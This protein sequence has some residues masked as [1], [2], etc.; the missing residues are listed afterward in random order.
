M[1]AY[2]WERA[3]CRRDGLSHQPNPARSR[4]GQALGSGSD[5][6]MAVCVVVTS[7]TTGMLISN[8]QLASESRRDGLHSIKAHGVAAIGPKFTTHY[9][10]LTAHYSLPTTC[11]WPNMRRGLGLWRQRQGLLVRLAVIDD[12]STCQQCIEPKPN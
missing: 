11:A 12:R 7:G 3:S 10:L 8:F 5:V 1:K 6:H 4:K 9:S 2:W